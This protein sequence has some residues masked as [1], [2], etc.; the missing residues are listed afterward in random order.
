MKETAHFDQRSKRFAFV[1][2]C[3]ICQ[4]FQAKGIVR[5]GFSSTIKPVVEEL[6]KQEVNII[7]MPCPESKFGGL[8]H[9]LGRS[10]K[11]IREYDVSEFHNL[12]VHEAVNVVG[13]IKAIKAN[14]FEVLA[15]LGL[16]YSPSCSINLQYSNRGTFHR[17]GI[18]IEKLKDRLEKEGIDVPFVGI[19]RRG[20]KI[21]V[22]RLREL[23]QKKLP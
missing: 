21:S 17:S 1:P 19:N 13:M 18:F 22:S 4:A 14:G 11:G 8:E 12:C 5:F 23:L 3:L 16:E 7:Q 6:L 9:G 20:I 2:F 10:P 15:I